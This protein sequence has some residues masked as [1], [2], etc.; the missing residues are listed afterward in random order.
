MPAVASSNSSVTVDLGSSKGSMRWDEPPPDFPVTP[1]QRKNTWATE[2]FASEAENSLLTLPQS[3]QSSADT[4]GQ[5][6][7]QWF[8]CSC[9]SSSFPADTL[10]CDLRQYLSARPG[11]GGSPTSRS[12]SSY[13]VQNFASCQSKCSGMHNQ[14]VI[15]VQLLAN[16]VVMGGLDA[17]SRT[18]TSHIDSTANSQ[19]VMTARQ[20]C[21]LGLVLHVGAIAYVV[22]LLRCD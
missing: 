19:V 10:G 12:A 7:E 11:S 22:C 9:L 13:P 3:A 4:S 16:H 8:A 5:C 17:A 2:W 1:V 15:K 21:T 20:Q 18:S 14:V 6:H